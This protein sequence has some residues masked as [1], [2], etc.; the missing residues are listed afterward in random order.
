MSEPA[1]EQGLGSRIRDRF[2]AY[3]GQELELPERRDPPRPA[4]MEP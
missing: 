3:D 1:A 4:D 2:A